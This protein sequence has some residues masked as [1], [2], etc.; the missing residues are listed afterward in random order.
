MPEQFS[1]ENTVQN[2]NLISQAGKTL[3]EILPYL[4]SGESDDFNF[5]E[6]DE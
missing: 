3:E 1:E 6:P 5:G 2:G 4:M